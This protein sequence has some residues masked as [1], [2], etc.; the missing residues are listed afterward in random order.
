MASPS[1][2]HL[3]DLQDL[4]RGVGLRQI[5]LVTGAIMFAY[6]I[7]HFLNHALGNISTEALAIGVYYHTEFWQFLPVAI[8]FYSACLVHTALGIWALYQRREFHWK[9][10]EPLQLTLGLSVP[11]LIVAH[12]VGVRLGQTLYGQEKLYP[13]ELYTFFISSPNRLWLML[14]VLVI[15]W[16]HG[17]IGLYFW[18]RLRPFFTRAAPYLLAAAVLIPTLAML[19]IYQGGRATME[20]YQDPDW[21]R[22]ELSVQKLGT[23]AQATT[24]EKITDRLT[25]GYLG[26]LGLVLLARGARALLE[27]RG[28]MIALSYG[29]GRTLRVPKGLSVLEA[30]LRY[31]VPHASVCGGRARCSTCRI[32]IIGDHAALPEPSPREAFVLH[33]VGTDDPSIRLAC[34][35]RPTSDLNFF[36]LFLPHTM[37]ANAHAAN[38]TRV[39][40][41]RYLVSMFVDMRGSTQLAEKRL[42]FDTVFIVNRFLGAV[43]QAVLEAGGRPN[44]F[45]GDGMLALFGLTTERQVACRQALRAAA[46]IAANIDELNQFLSHDLREPIRFGIGIHGGE[47][48]VGDIGYRDHM[49][50]TALGD[51]VNVAARLQDMTKALACEAV[52]SDEVRVTAG[53]AD[54]ALPAQ[55]VAIR[56]RNEPMTERTVEATR[57]LSALVD[58]R[59]AVAA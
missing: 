48:I 15:A 24:L 35:L 33:R 57:I 41:E 52:I 19:G 30:S 54:D 31:N 29:N 27:R 11:M 9:T 36:Q 7:S 6:L 47:V 58:D 37:S 56:G 51:A 14:A 55:E 13:Q 40:Q 49:V 16:V 45:I 32:R 1:R 23:A 21:R 59:R 2:E 12:V 5:R 50:F 10:I 22:E 8:T 46:L 4:A 53:L 18:L 20:D 44:Q 3:Q 26:L 25:I 43:S 17:C 28:G 34:Q 39:G 38:P 42:P